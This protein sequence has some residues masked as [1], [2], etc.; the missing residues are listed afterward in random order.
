MNISKLDKAE[1]LRVLY[2]NSK[3]LGFGV[4]HYKPIDMTIEEARE[5][6]EDQTSFDYVGGRVLKIR[7]DGGEMRT[8]LYNRDNLIT[9][10][11]ALK[12]AGLI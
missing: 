4:F 7:L 6:L 8:D 11:D 9:A 2:N 12:N 1:V 3:P 5:L 10:E